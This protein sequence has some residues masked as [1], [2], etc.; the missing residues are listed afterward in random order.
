[1]FFSRVK[2][3]IYLFY[4]ELLIW[5]SLIASDRIKII[6]SVGEIRGKLATEI[7]V[8]HS[9]LIEGHLY[10]NEDRWAE[11]VPLIEVSHL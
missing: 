4:N 2:I 8:P 6:V 1:M 3:Y 9:T 7:Q 5:V 11:I 10:G